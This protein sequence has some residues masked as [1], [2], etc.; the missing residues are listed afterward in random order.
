MWTV[1]FYVHPPTIALALVLGLAGALFLAWRR[2]AMRAV[3]LCLAALYVLI[4]AAPLSGLGSIGES[5]RYVVWNPLL[6]F[7]DIGAP[8]QPENFGI[9]LD[10][11]RVARYSSTEPT[12]AERA[13]TTRAED[14]KSEVLHVHEGPDG[15]LVVTD[16]EG[17]P[18]EPG[19]EPERAAV[20]TIALE[21][22]WRDTQAALREAEGPWSVTGGLVLQE[23][24]MNTLLFVPIGVAAFFAF[25]SWPARLLFGPAL[26][27]TIESTQWALASGRSVDT[28]DLL[29]NG[30]G[31]LIGTLTALMAVAIVGLFDRRSRAR[32]PA[33]SEHGH[34]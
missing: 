26:S 34:L 9:H 15:A 16:A 5:D 31:A 6:S 3:T 10:E 1:L 7:Q 33:L 30:V 27:L 2:P 19:S 17:A 25:S 18:V 20:E 28:G 13:E 11:Y 14:P 29:V 22:E 4:L 24:V 23:R 12:A 21:L 32:P 8:E